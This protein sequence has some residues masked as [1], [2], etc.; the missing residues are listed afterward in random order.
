MEGWSNNITIVM[1][2]R[3]LLYCRLVSTPFWLWLQAIIHF[4]FRFWPL[5]FVFNPNDDGNH[6][7]ITQ[8]ALFP[9]ATIFTHQK[10]N[11]CPWAIYTGIDTNY[12]RAWS[13]QNVKDSTHNLYWLNLLFVKQF[14]VYQK[15]QCG[16]NWKD[17][18]CEAT[19]DQIIWEWRR[20]WGLVLYTT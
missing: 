13:I 10:S 14:Y 15:A 6:E 3:D 19:K 7:R 11:L 20:Y 17:M 9:V 8:R 4:G 5:A 16:K 12:D 2:G 1:G 18:R